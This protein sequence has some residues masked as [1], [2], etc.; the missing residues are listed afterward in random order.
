MEYPHWRK[1]SPGQQFIGFS[2]TYRLDQSLTDD[3]DPF[4]FVSKLFFSIIL[5]H[6]FKRERLSFSFT[7]QSLKF[8]LNDD[9]T[10]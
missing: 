2:K 9:S 10:V 1:R 8:Y 3:I 7:I 5:D 6:L 4:R